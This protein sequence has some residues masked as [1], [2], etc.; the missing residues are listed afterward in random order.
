MKKIQSLLLSTVCVLAA[1]L[2]AAAQ[3]SITITLKDSTTLTF[4]SIDSVRF[5][6]GNFGTPTGVGV[7]IY[8]NGSTQSYDYLY[9]QIL[10]LIVQGQ[11][12]TVDA[13]VIT[14]AGGE[15]T[16]ATTVT[17]T[18]ATTG[19]SI[20]YTTDGTTPSATH[21]TLYTGPI[22]IS[23]TTTLRAIAVMDGVS[24]T[25]TTATFTVVDNNVNANKQNELNR[26][27]AA[28]RMEFPHLGTGSYL[29]SVPTSTYNH[30]EIITYQIE[31]DCAKKSNHWTCYRFDENTPDNNV[32][33]TQSTFSVDPNIPTQYQW[34]HANYT[35]SN[36]SRGHMCMSDDRQ[37]NEES[38]TQTFYTT[39]IHPQH[40]SHNAGVWLRLEEW[41]NSRGYDRSFCDTLY[42][43][44]AGT[45]DKEDQIRGYTDTDPLNGTSSGN[46][47]TS[48]ILIPQYFYMC[49]LAVKNGQ[50]KAIG[51][52]TEHT[53]GQQLG[54]ITYSDYAKSIDEIEELT[55]LDFFCN[56]PDDIEAQVEASYDMG[57][58]NQQTKNKRR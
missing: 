18:C 42:V 56:L 53:T 27:S 40:Q 19:A 36:F 16:Q 48:H 3:E 49:I 43:V 38:N 6:G 28:W 24:S 57:D 22:T 55:G 58:W 33:R 47:C 10:N 15:I 23:E 17:I 44:K 2:P 20:Y 50:Y 5:V 12:I 32:G 39:N 41:V 29:Y 46:Y 37:Y 51:F 21:G 25:I 30:Q 11:T 8:V 52:W 54:T 34:T 7:K 31:W 4:N 13:P 1:T 45:I 9:S 26:C 35:Y 14:P